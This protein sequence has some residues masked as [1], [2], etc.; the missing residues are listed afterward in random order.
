MERIF[1]QRGRRFARAGLG[2]ASLIGLAVFA[3]A[4]SAAPAISLGSLDGATGVRFE[5]YTRDSAG[6]TVASAG[7]FNHDGIDDLLIGA[8]NARNANG[9]YSGAV[10]V[11]F[12]TRAPFPA[13][14]VG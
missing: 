10:S 14:P 4:A 3:A 7:D 8:S 9:Q 2:C 5:G 13:I 1:E 12:G 6:S 11:V